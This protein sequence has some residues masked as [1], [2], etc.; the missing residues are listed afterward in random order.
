[1]SPAPFRPIRVLLADDHPLI[2]LGIQAM[3]ARRAN[4]RVIAEVATGDDAVR[5]ACALKPDIAL[6]DINMPG[7]GG[8]GAAKQLRQRLPSCRVIIISM[9]E[10]REYV[11]QAVAAGAKGYIQK[12]TAP[13]VLR[14]AIETVHYGRT[15]FTDGASRALLADV[16]GAGG[17][18]SEVDVDGL[19][20]RER[21]V[22]ILIA[23][24]ASNKEAAAKLKIGVRTVETHRERVIRKLGI[25]TTAGL[26]KYA[27]ANGLIKF[28]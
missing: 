19:T 27:L 5:L 12:D 10:D 23:E 2:R 21:E 4:I 13:E 20:S 26:T 3:L 25:R 22:L 8:L 1:M 18:M 11:R 6:L 15:F 17:R 9:H 16:V 7:L 28:K 24:G 14:D